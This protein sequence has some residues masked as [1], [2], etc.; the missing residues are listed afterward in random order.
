MK[1][2]LI[3]CSNAS[4]YHAPVFRNLSKVC[5]LKVLFGEKDLFHGYYSEEYKTYI[6][7]N[8]DV[9]KG[10]NFK[11]LNNYFNKKKKLVFFQDQIFMLQKKFINLILI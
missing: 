6:K 9:F 4:T 1:K 11:F 5:E 7:R 8:S 2:I 3:T 10:Y